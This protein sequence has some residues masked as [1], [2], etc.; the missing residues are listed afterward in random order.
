MGT[1]NK[2]IIIIGCGDAGISTAV[3]LLRM[4]KDA[5]ITIIEREKY[6]YPRCPLPFV[7]GGEIVG[8]KK[9]IKKIEDMFSG[10]DIKI[11]HDTV[12]SINPEENTLRTKNQVLEYDYLVMATGASSHVPPIKGSNFLGCYTLRTIEDTKKIIK[13]IIDSESAIVIGGGAIGLEVASAFKNHNLDVTV[14][15]IMDYIMGTSFDPGFSNIIEEYLT[16]NG[17]KILKGAK[18][19]EITERQD[20]KGEVG[21]VIVD[22]KFI[23]ADLVVFSTGIRANSELAEDAKIKVSPHGIVI[24]ERLQ[25]SIPNIYACGDCIEIKEILTGKKVQ[26]GYGTQ[27]D[28][29]GHIAGINIAGGK[30]IFEGTLNSVVTKAMDLEVG[31]TG[32]TQKEAKEG[33]YETVV[34]VV[35]TKTKPDYYPGT[36]DFWTH[37]IFDVKSERLLGAQIA[38]GEDV[39]G[40]VN[41]ASMALQKGNTLEDT[42]SFKYSY[43]PPICSAPSPFVSAAENAYKKLNRLRKIKKAKEKKLDVKTKK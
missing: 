3:T 19:N 30:G 10:T 7:I 5:E 1:K 15:E 17:I 31:R 27:A 22:R 6:F 21:G 32:L 38:G 2:K 8:T 20:R 39:V 12:L 37:L 25:T 28:R 23:P 16:G 43:A 9:I 35:K 40:Y 13:R 11:I 42:L 18:V 34:G 29:E 26:S 41:L 33:G 24:N 36:K 4:S 14:I